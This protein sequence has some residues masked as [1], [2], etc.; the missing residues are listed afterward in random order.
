LS[1]SNHPEPTHIELGNYTADV[2]HHATAKPFWYYVVQRKES[3]G[4]IDLVRFDT[5]EQG[6]CRCARNVGETQSEGDEPDNP[7]A[8]AGCNDTALRLAIR[9]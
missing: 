7:H 3:S 9:R 2:L 5:Y 4:V 8:L 1:G 6:N